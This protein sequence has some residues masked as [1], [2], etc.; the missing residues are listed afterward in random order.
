M[1]DTLTIT[2]LAEWGAA[3]RLRDGIC[4]KCGVTLHYSHH[5]R[6]TT[7]PSTVCQSDA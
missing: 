1:S 6:I 3:V 4:Q 7:S 2:T 5:S